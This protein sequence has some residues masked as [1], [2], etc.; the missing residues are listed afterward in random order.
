[1]KLTKYE[2]VNKHRPEDAQAD[3]PTPKLKKTVGMSLLSKNK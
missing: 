3:T 2:K 1:M